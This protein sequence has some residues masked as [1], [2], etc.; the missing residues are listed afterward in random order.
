VESIDY[1]RI[2]I[3]LEQSLTLGPGEILEVTV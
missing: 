1:G 2:A 3:V